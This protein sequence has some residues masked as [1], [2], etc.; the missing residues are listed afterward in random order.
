MELLCGTSVTGDSTMGALKDQF[1]VPLEMN[2]ISCADA[3]IAE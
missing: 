1:W 2:V 3:S